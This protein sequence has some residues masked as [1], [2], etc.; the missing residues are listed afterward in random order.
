MAIGQFLAFSDTFWLDLNQ[1]IKKKVK[2]LKVTACRGSHGI[3]LGK[4]VYSASN[5]FLLGYNSNPIFL[6]WC[7]K[8]TKI[9][10]SQTKPGSSHKEIHNS[11]TGTLLACFGDDRG[12]YISLGLLRERFYSHQT[13]SPSLSCPSLSGS[14]GQAEIWSHRSFSKWKMVT[15]SP[16]SV[17][18]PSKQKAYCT[19]WLLC[20]LQPMWLC[21]RGDI[22]VCLLNDA[23]S[24][25]VEASCVP[26]GCS[27]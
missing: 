24:K 1:I 14:P 4:Q 21:K 27:N 22:T 8:I 20:C 23:N 16:V 15:S 9:S 13:C 6:K 7:G 19:C 18:E 10:V 25:R 2:L 3:A 5:W 26:M 17:L 11:C 12:P